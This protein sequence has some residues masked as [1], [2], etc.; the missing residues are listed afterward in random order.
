MS[1]KIIALA[2]IGI[3]LCGLYLSSKILATDKNLFKEINEATES[4]THIAVDVDCSYK[5]VYTII[6]ERYNAITYKE[7][8][9]TDNIGV[10]KTGYVTEYVHVPESTVLTSKTTCQ[11]FG[12]D[13]LTDG[14]IAYTEFY[15]ELIIKK[16]STHLTKKYCYEGR[17]YFAGYYSN[18]KFVYSGVSDKPFVYLRFMKLLY[19]INV[20]LSSISYIVL[21][22]SVPHLFKIN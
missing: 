13:F 22:V 4:D 12:T 20:A 16:T 2:C 18:G 17:L 19:P 9:I 10:V 3:S 14:T 8:P 15:P 21:M 11:N 1:D 5:E 6:P 7:A